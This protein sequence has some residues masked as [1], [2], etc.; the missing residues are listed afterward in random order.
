MHP[1]CF[2]SSHQRQA[3]S[4]CKCSSPIRYHPKHPGTEGCRIRTPPPVQRGR[5]Q[6]AETGVWTATDGPSHARPVSTM[7]CRPKANIEVL[8]AE[9]SG[10]ACCLP[11]VSM[12]G[13][14]RPNGQRPLHAGWPWMLAKLSMHPK[15]EVLDWDAQLHPAR[16]AAPCV[17]GWAGDQGLAWVGMLDRNVWGMGWGA[18][19]KKPPPPPPHI[20]AI[21]L[22][23]HGPCPSPPSL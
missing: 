16:Q 8:H 5:S 7:Q 1:A 22:H 18:P 9:F 2:I 10:H 3:G 15:R 20:P 17:R 12:S 19:P 21:G 6:R 13:P 4:S 11:Q 23:E 14:S